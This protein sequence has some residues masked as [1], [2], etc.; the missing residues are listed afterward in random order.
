MEKSCP[1]LY[2]FVIFSQGDH[3][4]LPNLGERLA[5]CGDFRTMGNGAGG[6]AD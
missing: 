6:V 4:G 3:H 2:G 1:P 5:A